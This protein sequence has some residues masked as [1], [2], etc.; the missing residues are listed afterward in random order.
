MIIL[1]KA[2]ID[3]FNDW[4]GREAVD[5]KRHGMYQKWLR[6][7][8]DFCH[9]YGHGYLDKQ[10]L[11]LFTEKLEDKGQR[12]SQIEKASRA[13]RLYYR[14]AGEAEDT[15]PPPDGEPETPSK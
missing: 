2:L 1:P 14:M 15:L 11:G 4:L 12:S 7:Y 5:A 3:K 6:Y 9:K 8:L 10:S 13:V